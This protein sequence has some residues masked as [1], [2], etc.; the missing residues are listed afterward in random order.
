MKKLIIVFVM[1]LALAPVVLAQSN[2]VE[3]SAF[4][5]STFAGIVA[6]VSL[7]VTQLAKIFTRIG[8]VT[9]WKIL[10]SLLVGIALT[11]LAWWLKWA[12]FLA[13]MLWWQVLIQ[14][15]LSGGAACGIYDLLKSIFKRE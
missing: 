13:D 7:I 3:T 6:C 4:N 1:A 11:F 9:L 5:L 10:T 2:P 8:E 12:D 14:G 15:L